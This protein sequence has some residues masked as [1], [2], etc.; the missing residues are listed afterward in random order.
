M[1][2]GDFAQHI[3]NEVRFQIKN[4]F[5]STNLTPKNHENYDCPVGI[6]LVIY[7]YSVQPD[8]C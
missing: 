7:Y 3:K 5:S 8:T 4:Y 6:I 2:S 1:K